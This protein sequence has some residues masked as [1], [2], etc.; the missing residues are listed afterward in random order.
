MILKPLERDCKF[1]IAASASL[2][3]LILILTAGI[4]AAIPPDFPGTGSQIYGS[5]PIPFSEERIVKPHLH[6]AA[7][8]A[9]RTTTENVPIH[10]QA[11]N[12]DFHEVPCGAFPFP[13]QS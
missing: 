8:F 6:P 5:D 4:A 12:N 2:L 13:F 11:E 1:R 7:P 10:T 3:M 9:N